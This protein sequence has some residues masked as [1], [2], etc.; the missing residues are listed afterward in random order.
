MTPDVLGKLAEA[1]SERD[2]VHIAIVPVVAKQRLLPGEHVTAEG[3]KGR[4]K[5]PKPPEAPLIGIVDPFRIKAIEA[6]EHFW[7]LLYPGTI[8]SLR[9]EWTHPAFPDTP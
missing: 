9:H 3:Y 5:E 4:W 6:G 8:T 1:H 2:A 7:L